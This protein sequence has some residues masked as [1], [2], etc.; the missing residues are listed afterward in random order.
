V[1]PG[2]NF[3]VSGYSMR[4]IASLQVELRRLWDA[5]GPVHLT[6]EG[7]LRCDT[8]VLQLLA[9]FVRDLRA[10][11]REVVWTGDPATVRGAARI[12]DLA[13]LL[14]IPASPPGAAR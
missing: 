2:A 11:G 3:N 4:D 10:A 1:K 14:A 7:T 5:G 6:A 9:A 12:L 8:A 13:N